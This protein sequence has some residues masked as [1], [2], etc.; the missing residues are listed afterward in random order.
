AAAL[1][2]MLAYGVHP[3]FLSTCLLGIVSQRLVRTLCPHCRIGYDLSGAPETFADV[4]RWLEPGEGELIYS[5]PGCEHCFREGYVDRTGVFEV[6]QVNHEIRHF[7][8]DRTSSQAIREKAIEH[9]MLDLRR[10]ALLKVAKGIT[11]T[12]EV[13]RMISTEHLMPT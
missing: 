7:I 6:L 12:E 10:S 3:H 1:D 4:R 8:I 13:V 2:S 11:S 5:A 9:G